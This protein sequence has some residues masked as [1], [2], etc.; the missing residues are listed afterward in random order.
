M[1]FVDFEMSEFIKIMLSGSDLIQ[2]TLFK[3]KERSLQVRAVF[4]Q[5][6]YNFEMIEVVELSLS[7]LYFSRVVLWNS[8]IKGATGLLFKFVP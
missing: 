1:C 2:N 5:I 7:T 4:F 3:R 6:R 8:L